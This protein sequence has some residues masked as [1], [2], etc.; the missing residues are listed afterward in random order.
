MNCIMVVGS[1]YES[2]P[3]NGAAD[4]GHLLNLRVF[5]EQFSNCQCRRQHELPDIFLAGSYVFVFRLLSQQ[6]HGEILSQLTG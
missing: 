1:M 4:S 5:W 2:I 3:Q 6:L